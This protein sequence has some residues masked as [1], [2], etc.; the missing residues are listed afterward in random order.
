MK[1]RLPESERDSLVKGKRHLIISGWL[2]NRINGLQIKIKRGDVV[3]RHFGKGSVRKS[4]I[5]VGAIRP[6]AVLHRDIKILERP[7]SYTGFRIGRDIG[8]IQQAERGMKLHPASIGF[9]AGGGMTA[10]AVSGDGEVAP[11]FYGGLIIV[12]GR[13]PRGLFYKQPV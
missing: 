2:I 12:Q 3:I 13:W 1:Q 7:V 10:G 5:Q 6:D 9:A 8:G 11:F 4:R